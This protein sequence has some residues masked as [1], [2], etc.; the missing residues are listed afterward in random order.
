[1]NERIKINEYQ[2][3]VVVVRFHL[4]DILGRCTGKVLPFAL[5]ECLCSS[6]SPQKWYP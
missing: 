4:F 6:P 3:Y 2:S 5:D 1:M